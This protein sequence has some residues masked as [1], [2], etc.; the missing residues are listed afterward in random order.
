[1]RVFACM[2]S[3]LDGKI[4]PA[5]IEHFV[6]LG[7]KRDLQHLE[8]LRDEADA[9]LY[10][11]ETFRAWPKPHFGTDK[12][13]VLKH[14]IMSRSMSLARNAELFQRTD[15]P[16]TVFT[17]NVEAGRA[18]LPGHVNFVQTENIPALLDHIKSCGVESL[19]VEGGG[20]V[21]RQLIEVQA[22][23]ELYLTVVPRFVGQP[24][25]PGLLG[26]KPLAAPCKVQVLSSNH[27]DGETYLHMKFN[28]L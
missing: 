23:E 8:S 5:D 20:E 12:Q 22:L 21:L 19:M 15:I 7:S 26:G 11:A 17:N 25:A 16:V 2:A 27:V 3:S 4:G 18:T 24:A 14:F 13:R 6:P 10:G 28:Y 9:V 1:M